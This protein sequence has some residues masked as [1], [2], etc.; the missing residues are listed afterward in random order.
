MI[1]PGYRDDS[2]DDMMLVVVSKFA[3][4]YKSVMV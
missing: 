4:A 1:V 3:A 2:A